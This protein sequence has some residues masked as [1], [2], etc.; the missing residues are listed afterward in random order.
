MISVVIPTHNPNLEFLR[1]TL[2]SLK[3]QIQH[4]VIIVENPQKTE[5]VSSLLE[6]FSFI[7]EESEAGANNARNKGA[8]VSKYEYI[9]FIDDDILL[10]NNLL[11]RYVSTHKSTEAA[12]L[13]GPV[14][15]RYIDGKPRWINKHF[16][17]YLAR[18]DCGGSL[19]YEIKKEWELHVPLVSANMSFSK[20]NF[21]LLG[22]FD[23]KAGYIGRA[24]LAPNDELGIITRASRRSPG[25][26]YCP[27][28]YVTHLIPKERTTADYMS[29]RMYGQGVAD[30]LSFKTL[31]PKLTPLEIYEK[32]ILEHNSL[33][34]NDVASFYCLF[35]EMNRI[36]RLYATMVYHKSRTEYVKGLLSQIG[37]VSV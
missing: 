10:S 29:R 18:L 19:P 3:G 34:I 20:K 37:E 11:E 26:V 1:Q 33:V 2:N 22:G 13:G 28:N 30:F 32:V 12:V 24:V 16:E 5:R 4:E 14:H 15:L 35:P 17:G 8:E 31:H 7:H 36:D 6:E 25:M 21:N 23:S 27:K 9:L